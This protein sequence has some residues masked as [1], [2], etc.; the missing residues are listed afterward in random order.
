LSRSETLDD[1]A[2]VQK[3]FEF[4]NE[5]ELHGQVV[6]SDR[7]KAGWTQGFIRAEGSFGV[8]QEPPLVWLNYSKRLLR[9]VGAPH[10]PRV[11]QVLANYAPS[12][13]G[14]WLIKAT[15]DP[16]G[17]PVTS[18]FVT[19]R[20]R[21]NAPPPEFFWAVM[22]SPV[23]NAFAA[24]WPDK[25]QTLVKDWRTLPVPNPSPERVSAIV[26]AAKAFLTL[27]RNAD[28]LMVVQPSNS[29]IRAAL[30]TLDAEVLKLYGLPVRLER[31]LLDYFRG[32][33]RKGVGCVFGDY[34][35]ADF[36][37]FVPLHKF[38]SPAYRKST[39]ENVAARMKP[40]ES[41]TVLEALRAA[42]EAF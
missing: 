1:L 6:E 41:A 36:E 5:E 32:H 34:F 42:S 12:V 25:R 4:K 38:I 3:G 19:I 16:D 15:L 37:S 40:G 20:R 39:V 7:P 29:K 21:V 23:A 8:W 26:Q 33:A 35:P 9:R 24:S 11:P 30:L 10:K 2:F 27:M 31:Q 28:G 14:P 17:R 13:P 22:N 18:R